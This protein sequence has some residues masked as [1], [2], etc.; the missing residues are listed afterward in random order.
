MSHMPSEPSHAKLILLTMIADSRCLH[1]CHLYFEGILPK[2]PY[3]PCLRMADRTLLAGY[4]RFILIITY[5]PESCFKLQTMTSSLQC[6]KSL[7]MLNAWEVTWN[8]ASCFQC[9]FAGWDSAH[10]AWSMEPKWGPHRSTRAKPAYIKQD[11][12]D[13]WIKVQLKITLQST[14]LP[15]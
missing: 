8:R 6:F 7:L 14:L 11:H 2:G 4:P 13:P 12:L 1:T 3:P 10:T 9:L 5:Y 15:H